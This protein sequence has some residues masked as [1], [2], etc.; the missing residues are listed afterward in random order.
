MIILDDRHS[1][2][3]GLPGE[4]GVDDV[5]LV[6]Q[7]KNFHDDGSLDFTETTLSEDLAAADNVGVL[8]DTIL[9]N[10]TYDPHFK[11][12]TQRVRFRLLNGSNARVYQL[13]FPDDR[14]F[15]LVAVDNGL[16]KR[17]QALT[18][19]RLAPGERA[20]IVVA[21][22]PGEEAVLRSFR[23]DLKVDFPSGR[24]SGGDD[25]FDIIALRAAK[26]LKESPE[27]PTQVPGAPATIKVPKNPRTR[28][29]RFSG[30]QIN[31]RD[32]AMDRVD[33][34]VPAG[35][36]EIW[37]IERGDGQV[38]AFHIHGATFNVL[39]VLGEEPPVF[40]RGPKDT[41]YLPGTGTIRLA[42]QFDTLTDDERPYMYHCHIL[43]HEDAGMMG[44]VPGRRTRPRGQGLQGPPGRQRFAPLI[45]LTTAPLAG[46]HDVTRVASSARR[47]PQAGRGAARLLSTSSN[48]ARA[49]A[50]CA[51][52]TALG[53]SG[54]GVR[55]NTQPTMEYT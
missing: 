43:R 51:R 39:E 21:F 25:T 47:H 53:S 7:D 2:R 33:E 18:R 28:R 48:A 24:F 8:G 40:M 11:V 37:E 54:S 34:V 17:P 3:S 16:L 42:V 4:Y 12:T 14:T 27:L 10:G 31:G 52:S 20:E 1:L 23:P 6:I 46:P 35:T 13:G 45:D 36:T 30:T 38:H 9:V 22:K 29:F 19:L 5:P 26:T 41:A 44:P 32:M 15:H 50:I 49:A 55:P